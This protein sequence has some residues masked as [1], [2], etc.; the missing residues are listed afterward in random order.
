MTFQPLLCI[1]PRSLRLAV[2]ALFVLSAIGACSGPST[3]PAT[4]ETQQ[5]VAVIGI[6]P[7]TW[8]VIGLDS[9][10]VGVG[11]ATYPV[12]VR[13]TNPGNVAATNVTATLAFTMPSTAITLVGSGV[14]M[15]TSIGPG[16]SVDA[17]FDV[18]VTPVNDAPTAVADAP[19]VAKDAGPTALAVL[20]NDLIAPDTGETLTIT[21]VTQPANGTVVITGGGTGLTFQPT[22]G[23]TGTTTFTYRSRMAT[24]A[25]RRRR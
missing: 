13:I 6:A 7:I 1:P 14:D 11:P 18:T 20:A 3:E 25:R 17:Y 5:A 4:S 23:F 8:N 10:G 22:A 24:A 21:A 2:S 16:A 15:F 19:T 12:G 9:N